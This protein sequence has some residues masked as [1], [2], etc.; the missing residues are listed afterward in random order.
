MQLNAYL[1]F[2]GNC[3]TAFQ[4]YQS[5]LGG[6]VVTLL[7]FKDAP[8]G[9]PCAPEDAEKIMHVR[10]AVGD[11]VLMGSDMPT[12]MAANHIQG[13]ASSIMLALH[14]NHEC[15]ALF[16]QLAKEGQ[17]QMDLGFVFWGALFGMLTDKFGVQWILNSQAEK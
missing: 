9:M 1:H 14:D 6:E 8:A 15:R 10:L 3:E 7:K 13:N 2:N 12:T 5:I 4:Y 11:S 17:V 16:D